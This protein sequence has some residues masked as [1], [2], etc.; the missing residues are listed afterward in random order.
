MATPAAGLPELVS[1]T[2]L[3]MGSGL[4]DS[5][6]EPGRVEFPDTF[7]AHKLR[8]PGT[9]PT[10]NPVKQIMQNKSSETNPWPVGEDEKRRHT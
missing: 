10:T 8:A 6:Q 4:E 5:G 7:P 9:S 3:D 2:W 1:R